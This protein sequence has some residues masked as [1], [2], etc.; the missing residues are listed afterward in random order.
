[1][2]MRQGV[3]FAVLIV[4][5]R[6]LSPEDFGV[7][8]LL[9]L[10]VGLG[11]V[12]VDGGF[13]AALIQRQEISRRDESTVFFFNL[14]MGL[15]AALFLFAAAPLIAEYL[16]K[17]I[18]RDLTY[19][20]ALNVFIGSFGA[21]HTTLLTK[22][23]NLKVLAKIG[24]ICTGL[25][26]ALAI[27][28]A[29]KGFGAW[30]LAIQIVA[31]SLIST[32]LLWLWHPWRPVKAFSMVS[33]RSYF[34]FGGYLMVIAIIDMLHTNLYSVLIGKFYR[35]S[36]V[37]Y[38]DRAQKT[39]LLPANFI[40]LIINRVAFSAFS[41]IAEDKSRLA[42]LFRKAQTLV[43]FVNVPMLV[44]M[45]AL[46]EPLI[47]LLFGEQWLPSVPILQVLG[48]VGLMWPMHVLNINILK[49]QGRT[50][51][52]FNIMLIKKTVAIGLT[53]VGSFYGILSIAWAQVAASLFSFLVNAYYSRVYLNYGAMRQILDM[54]PII[55]AA[56]P[57]G[58]L[59]WL[60]G[61]AW[62]GNA[63]MQLSVGLS[64]GA[65]FYLAMAFFLRINALR[66]IVVL[67]R[68]RNQPAMS[69]DGI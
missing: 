36:D 11:N 16:G 55:A 8:A 48:I 20:M 34:R 21:I 60:V 69:T 42:Q 64:A 13:S 67:L 57:A 38:Y 41:S 33:L 2:L 12:F 54:L 68:L 50:D 25:S 58:G 3:Q 56:L 4:L 29:L 39:Q 40:M 19:A 9:A 65:I 6:I 46:A 35:V 18:L 49:A 62:Q 51:L 66:E 45:I 5:A 22:E 43:M 52:F 24:A 44:A 15:L 1:M 59:M 61:H 53:V 10:F 47:R 14:A 63:M 30:S 7:I 37:G 28:L 32:L 17:P 23:L 27:F 31:A 26:G